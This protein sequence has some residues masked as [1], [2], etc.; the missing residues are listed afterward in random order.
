MNFLAHIYLSNNNDSMKIG[1]FI[2]DSVPGRKY[3]D[4]PKQIQKGIL[5]HRHIDTFTDTHQIWRKSKKLLVP[6]YNHYA[7]VIIDMYFDYF[8][9]KNWHKYSEVPLEKYSTNFYKLLED[10]FDIL[11]AKIQNFYPIMVKE[12]WLLQYQSLTGLKYILTQMDRRTK[13]VSKMS[14]SWRQLVVYHQ[15]LENNFF[16]FF[17]LLEEEVKKF[18]SI[19]KF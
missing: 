14:E 2:A 13:G 8:L 19:N 7:A 12:N 9:A 16:E 6:Y 3:E 1:N 4:Y 15:E 10:N 5:L 11:P 18:I 17:P